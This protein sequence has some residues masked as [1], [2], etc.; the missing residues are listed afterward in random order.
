L[1]G[2]L[3]FWGREF[4]PWWVAW[5]QSRSRW[6][7]KGNPEDENNP[8]PPPFAKEEYPLFPMKEVE[9]GIT[10]EVISAG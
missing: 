4:Y 10:Q 2:W 3:K 9:T 5:W 8:P 6:V 7:G 1:Y